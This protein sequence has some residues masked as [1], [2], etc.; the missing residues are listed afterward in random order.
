M[1]IISKLYHQW[2]QSSKSQGV[3][4]MYDPTLINFKT[5]ISD[6]FLSGPITLLIVSTVL[7]CIWMISE[8]WRIF[9]EPVI[10]MRSPVQM[11]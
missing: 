10:S 9:K 4:C 11:P 5:F 8:Q 2:T 1:I 6:T 3:K 7:F